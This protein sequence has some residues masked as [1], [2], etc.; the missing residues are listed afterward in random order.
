M[1]ETGPT[2][3][4]VVARVQG[5]FGGVPPTVQ[6]DIEEL[7]SFLAEKDMISLG[8]APSPEGST[9][10]SG[11]REDVCS[12]VKPYEK[13]LVREHEP[14]QQLTA[15]SGGGGGGGGG[16]TYYYTTTYYYPN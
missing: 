1:F 6:G 2:I 9:P 4:D 13:P 7:V 10:Q 11:E 8:A 12:D 15:A 3:G 14:L 16:G 5:D